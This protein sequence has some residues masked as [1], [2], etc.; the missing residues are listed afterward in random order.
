MVE[1]RWYSVTRLKYPSAYF[2][3][4]GT[5]TRIMTKGDI[6][7]L[8]P[9]GVDVAVTIFTPASGRRSLPYIFRRN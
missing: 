1:I 6:S 4:G 8:L 3:P 9:R 2:L 5:T 7:S